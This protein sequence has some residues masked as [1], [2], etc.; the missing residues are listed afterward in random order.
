MQKDELLMAL[1][2]CGETEVSILN[3]VKFSIDEVLGCMRSKPYGMTFD[4]L[5]ASVIRLGLDDLQTAVNDRIHE[6]ET[7][8][9]ERVLNFDEQKEL[10]V[11]NELF[12]HTDVHFCMSGANP[13]VWFEWHDED[14]RNYLSHAV[15]EFEEKT[16]L[17]F[18]DF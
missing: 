13:L 11:L 9:Y 18:S 8:S 4:H 5:M 2:G 10:H 7:I 15:K 17:Q 3:K 14:Y 16:G 12:P 1:L 6:L